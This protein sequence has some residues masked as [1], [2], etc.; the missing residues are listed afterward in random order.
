[1]EL[2]QQNIGIDAPVDKVFAYAVDPT[3]SP[4]WLP[5]LVEVRNVAG[6]GAGQRWEWTHKMVRVPLRGQSTVIAHIPNERRLTKKDHCE[7]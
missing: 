3:T 1:M 6:T 2:I 5:S 4:E 7:G